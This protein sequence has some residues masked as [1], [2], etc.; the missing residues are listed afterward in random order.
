MRLINYETLRLE[1]FFKNALPQYAILSHT[2]GKQEVPF[3]R[4][5]SFVTNS[6]I[7][8]PEFEEGYQKIRFICQQALKDG[9]SYTLVDTCYINKSFNVDLSEAINSMFQ[10]CRDIEVYYA[11]LSNVTNNYLNVTFVQSR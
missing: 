3:A 2:W 8:S 1:E 9:L 5:N 10:Y 7:L 4:F 6:E 11:Y